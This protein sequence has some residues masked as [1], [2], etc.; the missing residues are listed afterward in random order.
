MQSNPQFQGF[1]QENQNKSLNQIAA[2]HGIDLESLRA[3]MR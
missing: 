2:E 1:M 3:L